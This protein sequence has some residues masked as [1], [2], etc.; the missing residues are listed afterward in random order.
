M[1]YIHIII[2]EIEITYIEDLAFEEKHI[3][4]IPKTVDA[5]ETQPGFNKITK[6]NNQIKIAHLE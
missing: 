6:F 2:D 3:L 4:F 5:K 1:N